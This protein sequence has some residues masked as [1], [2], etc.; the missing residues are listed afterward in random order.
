MSGLSAQP[1]LSVIETGMPPAYS[2]PIR[3]SIQASVPG[4]AQLV[5]TLR[6]A[7]PSAPVMPQSAQTDLAVVDQIDLDGHIRNAAVRF[8][9]LDAGVERAPSRGSDGPSVAQPLTCEKSAA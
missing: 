5:S 3:T 1:P 6:Y 4:A 8:P 2:P 9:Y 7:S